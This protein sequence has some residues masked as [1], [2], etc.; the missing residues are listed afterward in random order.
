MNILVT[1]GLGYIG[2]HA[3][4]ALLDE[5]HKVYIIDN[6]ENGTTSNLVKGATLLKT[7]LSNTKALESDLKNYKIDGVFHLYCHILA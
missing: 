3:V 7:R 2:A 4:K 6:L 1:G 5:K